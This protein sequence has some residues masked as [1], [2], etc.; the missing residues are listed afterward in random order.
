MRD[1]RSALPIIVPLIAL[2][3]IAV[4]ILVRV[5][6]DTSEKPAVQQAKVV[7]RAP[8]APKHVDRPP[9][10]AQQQMS[11][12]EKE[13][14]DF[15]NGPV[16]RVV[17]KGL[18][19]QLV[20]DPFGRGPAKADSP[21]VQ[22]AKD[23]EDAAT[24]SAE[25][26]KN[27][28]EAKNKFN[29][30][31]VADLER[32]LGECREIVKAKAAAVADPVVVKNLLKEVDE[33]RING[34]IPTAPD[35]E[36]QRKS[37]LEARKVAARVLYLAYQST[38][39][40]LTKALEVDKALEIKTEMD[41]FVTKER[42][43]LGLPST[44]PKIAADDKA[45]APEIEP[46][47]K[48]P[49]FDFSDFIAKFVDEV[50]RV[51]KLETGAKRDEELRKTLDRLDGILRSHSLRFHFPIRE[52]THGYGGRYEVQLDEPDEGENLAG[53]DFIR[54]YELEGSLAREATR[55]RPGDV[56]EVSGKPR[57]GAAGAAASRP[58]PRLMNFASIHFNT[59]YGYLNYQFYMQNFDVQIRKRPAAPNDDSNAA[60]SNAAKLPPAMRRAKD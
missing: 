4:A 11:E 13:I 54:S 18:E 30:T 25:M 42:Q 31:I 59:R 19:D 36:A 28:R 23:S 53:I 50:E 26:F 22:T 5:V 7:S 40:E 56:F 51:A 14:H 1:W 46:D 55:I 38:V 33:L 45:E 52:V 41:E 10:K 21:P 60:K 37:H 9:S 24:D 48:K 32:I 49:G 43:R 47:M 20:N 16:A 6:R 8:M 29:S 12:R 34:A 2:G 17:K 3:V 15:A 58:G 44:E 27:L 39:S 35:F 57:L